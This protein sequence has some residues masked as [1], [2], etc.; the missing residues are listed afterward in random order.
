MKRSD[1]KICLALDGLSPRQACDLAGLLAPWIYAAKI[2][3][4]YDAE[5]K[6]LLSHLNELGVTP[7]IDYKI[8][9]TRDTAGLRIQALIEN[10]AKII[11]THA[12]GG[13]P[14]MKAA[15]EATLVMGEATAEIW[16][17]T[18]LTSLDDA[19][20]RRIYG[21]DRTREQ[22]VLEL[23][24]MGK[25]AGA[26]GLVCSAL[27]VGMLSAHPNLQGIKLVVPGTRSVGV[28][29]GQQKRSGTPL[30]AI[31][32]GATH[33]VAGSQVTKA[34]DPVAAFKALALEIGMS[35]D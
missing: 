20:I 11:T 18:L 4:L 33:L 35:L 2:H 7:W 15:V 16:A 17:I 28:D 22:I 14:M 25:E 26:H 1:P 34:K 8:H 9:D 21:S 27:E 6:K 5:G 24:L 12:S 3:N 29:L 19:E 13:I 32:D 23:A 10:G 30:Q 31:T